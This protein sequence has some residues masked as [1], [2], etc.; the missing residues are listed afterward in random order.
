MA[1]FKTLHWLQLN[2]LSS[3]YWKDIELLE[4]VQKRTTIM[5]SGMEHLSYEERLRELDCPASRREDYRETLLQ[6]FCTS[7]GLIRKKGTN[8]LAGSVE[9]GQEVMV[10]N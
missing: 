10:L 7:R 8:M 1:V 4:W 5:I 6:P 2:M 3:Q 9:I